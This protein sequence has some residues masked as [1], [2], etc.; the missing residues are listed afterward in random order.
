MPAIWPPISSPAPVLLKAPD[1]ASAPTIKNNML[2]GM[3]EVASLG[4][5]TPN[6]TMASAPRTVISQFCRPICCANMSAR[7]SAKK[8]IIPAYS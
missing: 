1:I 6:S 8:M 7:A 5:N 4:F 3:D 2:N